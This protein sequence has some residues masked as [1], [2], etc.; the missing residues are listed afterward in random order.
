MVQLGEVAVAA[1]GSENLWEGA[2]VELA[3]VAAGGGADPE[4]VA[5]ADGPVRRQVAGD[6]LDDAVAGGALVAG[7]AQHPPEALGVAQVN[8]GVG[9]PQPG[10]PGRRLARGN[11]EAFLLV[12]SPAVGVVQDR[13]GVVQG[14]GELGNSRWLASASRAM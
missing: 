13:G 12:L 1:L 9:P 4:P 10:G 3:G 8:A 6:R 5:A 11:S 7:R 14:A 2:D